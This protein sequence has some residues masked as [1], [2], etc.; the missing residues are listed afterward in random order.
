[1]VVDVGKGWFPAWYFPTVD[2]RDAVSW[3]L[4]YGGLA[5]MGHVFSF[6][7]RFRGGKGVATS[8][9]VLAA[10]APLPMAAA[11]LVW[12]VTVALFRIVSLGS[13]AAAVSVPLAAELAPGSL[14]GELRLFL[15]AM[16]LFVLWA[17][18]SNI[19]RL[20]SGTEPRIKR[21]QSGAEV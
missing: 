13:L 19:R 20:M 14:D 8:A 9:G 12:G 15:W 7:V 11:A 6:W 1:M 2:G 18:R 4:L 10:V 21:R 17:H 5:V 3:A 16:T